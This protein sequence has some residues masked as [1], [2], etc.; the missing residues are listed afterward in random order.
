MGYGD[1]LMP[2]KLINI[3]DNMSNRFDHNGIKLTI[4]K[5]DSDYVCFAKKD[6]E[7]KHFYE[8]T[9]H[10]SVLSTVKAEIAKGIDW[11][12]IPS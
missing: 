9:D 12:Q 11:D 8:D 10:A 2:T 5:V 3:G 6:G 7:T 4:K 1:S